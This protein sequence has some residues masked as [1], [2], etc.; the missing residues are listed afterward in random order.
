[1]LKQI[2]I[3]LIRKI[4]GCRTFPLREMRAEIFR[5]LLR[6]WEHCQPRQ[7][8]FRRD[9]VWLV[10]FLWLLSSIFSL[11]WNCLSYSKT[12]FFSQPRDS[13]DRPSFIWWRLV[14]SKFN[15]FLKFRW[16]DP[17]GLW[18]IISHFYYSNWEGLHKVKISPAIPPTWWD[19]G[20][21]GD[22]SWIKFF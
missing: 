4:V 15:Y 16:H 5:C 13:S 14:K 18:Y 1:M 8:Y 6:W 17:I 21:G 9:E 12:R 3:K 7:E 2:T 22:E 19:R 11:N 10:S 20:K